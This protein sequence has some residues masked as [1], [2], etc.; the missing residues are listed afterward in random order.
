MKLRSRAAARYALALYDLAAS[1]QAVEPVAHDLRTMRE[2]IAG[3]PELPDFLANYL[4]P[5]HDRATILTRLFE[6]LVHPLTWRFLC[7]VEAKRRLSLL[8]EMCESFLERDEEHQGIVRGKLTSAFALSSK[9]TDEIA[10]R[11]GQRMG[12]RVLLQ[13]E[14]KP[15]LLGGYRLRV[16]DMVYDL[17]LAA[18]LRMIRQGMAAA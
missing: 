7:F 1:V 13:T 9:D 17:S 5:R 8:D 15:E 2:W 3:A 14:E 12:K 16:G 11:A 6:P 18:R 4:L 10:V